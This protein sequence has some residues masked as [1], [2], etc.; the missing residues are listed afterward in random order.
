MP[1]KRANTDF[2]RLPQPPSDRSFLT[3]LQYAQSISVQLRYG[4]GLSVQFGLENAG[5]KLKLSFS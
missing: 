3:Q 5:Y 1:R 2:S 4:P